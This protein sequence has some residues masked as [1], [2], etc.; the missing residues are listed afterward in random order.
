MKKLL[1][2]LIFAGFA[3]TAAGDPP[4]CDGVSAGQIEWT[5]PGEYGIIWHT[6]DGQTTGGEFFYVDNGS[7]ITW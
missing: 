6:C 2:S 3:L 5:V 7:Y 1:F 4:P